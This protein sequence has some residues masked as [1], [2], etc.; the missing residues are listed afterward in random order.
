MALL[1]LFNCQRW[2]YNRNTVEKQFRS[3]R[4]Y[5]SFFRN[6][7]TQRPFH[8]CV[9]AK[10]VFQLTFL[11]YIRFFQIASLVFRERPEFVIRPCAPAATAAAPSPANHRGT[12]APC[13]AF[14][15]GGKSVTCTRQTAKEVQSNGKFSGRAILRKC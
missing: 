6:K 4:S 9:F 11:S 3:H 14:Q 2:D 7:K 12:S 8:L 10:T 15:A 13:K 5:F 1:F